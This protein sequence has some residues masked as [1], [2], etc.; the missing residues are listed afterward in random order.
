MSP[1]EQRS[2]PKLDTGG[3]HTPAGGYIL[4]GLSQIFALKAREQTGFGV[5]EALSGEGARLVYRASELSFCK[6]K[7]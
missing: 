4:P 2:L 5:T 3:I 7:G 1:G 6:R